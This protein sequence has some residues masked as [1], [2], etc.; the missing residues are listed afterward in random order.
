MRLL[1][2]G[3]PGSG[4]G[5]QSKKLSS[6]LKIPHISTGDIFRDH[7]SRNTELGQKIRKYM[8]RGEYVPDEIVNAVVKE[9]IS[10]PDCRKGFILDGYPRTLKQLEALD[11]ILEE[12]GEK[13]DAVIYL[14][15]S[16]EEVMKRLSARR[17]C[18]SC[19]AVYNLI[20]NPPR[21]DEVCDSCN[22]KLIQRDDDLPEVVKNRLYVY[23]SSVK[24]IIEKYQERGLLIYINAEGEMDRVLE[25]ILAFIKLKTSS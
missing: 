23:Y 24:P 17:V 9:R 6:F 22:T 14:H 25:R 15:V 12:L 20:Y 7:L 18:P 11:E 4:K 3:P 2:L 13:I 21:N 5:T 1:I 19:G 10:F 8:E 16:E